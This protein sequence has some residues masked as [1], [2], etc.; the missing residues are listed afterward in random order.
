MHGKHDD[1]DGGSDAGNLSSGVEAVHYRHGKVQDDGVGLQFRHFLDGNLAVLGLAAYQPIGVVLDEKSK[2][3]ANGGT[4]V[5]DENL[6]V[7]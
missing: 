3:M 4:V 7:A 2:Q 1:L 5:G 6:G